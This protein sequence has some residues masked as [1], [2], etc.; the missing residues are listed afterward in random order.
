M[1]AY[2]L[3]GSISSVL[4]GL[5]VY[6]LWI[7]LNKIRQRRRARHFPA[8][9]R[10]SVNQFFSSYVAFYGNFLF[11]LAVPVLNHYLVWTRLAA[12]LLI[13]NI[14]F[15]IWW[16]RRSLL[17]LS[18]LMVGEFLLLA[19]FVVLAVRPLPA[20]LSVANGVIVLMTLVLVQGTVQQIRVV[21]RAQSAGVLSRRMLL[22]TLTK[23]AST[24]AFALTMPL[25]QSWPLLLL[26]GASIVTRGSLLL[27]VLK[28]HRT[29]E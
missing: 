4:F 16:E 13:L 11:G 28:T 10:L 1:S 22:F 26:N 14:L 24:L 21:H 23:D 27:L 19:G 9:D 7:Q 8:T 18:A 15:W 29:E 25:T 20:L 3:W 2:H 17:S 6:G 12:L 5:T